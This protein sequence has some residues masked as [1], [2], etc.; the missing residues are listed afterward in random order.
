MPER[1]FIIDGHAHI[2]QAYY[3]LPPLINSSG[4]VVHAAYGFAAMLRKVINNH[5]PDYMVVALDTPGE[6]FRNRL[7]PDYKA[8]RK[9]TPQDLVDQLPVVE[10]IIRSYGAP[11]LSVPG[12]EADDVIGSLA[13]TAEKRG[14]EAVIVST[15]KDV[16][17]LITDKVRIYHASK[18]EWIDAATLKEKKGITPSQVVELLTLTGDSSDNVPG[19]P[20]VGPVTAQKW[21]AEFGSIANLLANAAQI[22]S[23]KQRDNL[24]AASEKLELYRTLVTIKTDLDMAIDLE[25]YRLTPERLEEADRLYEELE[26]KSLRGAGRGKA[27]TDKPPQTGMLAFE[28]APPA[29]EPAEAAISS[30]KSREHEYNLVDSPDAFEKFLGELREQNIFAVDLETTSRFPAE[31]EI[32]GWSFCWGSPKAFYIPVRSRTVAPTL[33]PAA[34]AEA[35]RPILEDPARKKIGQNIKYDMIVM[36]GA[37]IELAGVAFDTMIASHVLFP[38]Q[39]RHNIDDMALEY[40][41]YEK[42]S[43]EQLIGKGRGQLCMDQVDVRQVCEYACED[44]D[45]AF[46]LYEFLKPKLRRQGLWELF[47][48]VEMPLVPVLAEMEFRGVCID[49]AHLKKLSGELGAQA[50][51][52]EARIYEAAGGAFNINSPKQLAEV[53]FDKL[54]LPSGKRT[55]T[56]AST[57]AEVLSELSGMHPLPGLVLEYRSLVKLKSTYADA[58]VEMANRRTGRLHTSFHQTGTATG[59]L[60]SSDPNLQNIPVRTDVGR[61]IRKAFIAPGPDWDMISADY[62]QIELR[63]LAH[64]SGDEALVRAFREDRDIHRFVAAEIAGAPESE[65]TAEMRNRA[66]TVNFGIIYGQ[67]P[68]RLAREQD[69]PLA[70]AEAFIK[71]YFDRYRGVKA[72]IEATIEN[73]RRT[74]FVSTILGR[75]RP[76]PNIRSNNPRLRSAEERIAVN[77]IMQ[78]SAADL[79]KV[80]MSRIH[81]SLPGICAEAR[82]LL[83]IHDEL[84]LESPRAKT[85][86]VGEI[87]RAEMSGAMTLKVPLKVNVS[88]GPDWMEAH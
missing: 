67:S 1:I 51:A 45:I 60:S 15:D 88:S 22:K 50:V 54:G 4:K 23:V 5:R 20:N 41:R 79:I 16:E 39:A 40:L 75:K 57:D 63:M 31:A 7:F 13:A 78:G 17:Q 11:P 12:F 77:T 10:R 53:L 38:N 70:D 65:V 29:S 33:N 28:T 87:V 86:A 48:T 85:Q 24:L 83:Q 47:E 8:N 26:F 35:L 21:L 80:A 43:T 84:L 55:Q 81:R 64:F 76:L 42:I 14:L 71:A 58:L 2:Y 66:K 59:R 68:G 56:G 27:R 37:G 72:F 36:K 61:Q 34:T 9:E 49:T 52:L 3:A 19:V 69:I 6:T 30:A 25:N 82:M 46:A 32:V 73:A 44:A 62:S 18:E 74:G